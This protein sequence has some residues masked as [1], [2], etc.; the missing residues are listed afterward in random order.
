M[1]R[2]TVKI[3]IAAMSFMKESGSKTSEA[4]GVATTIKTAPRMKAN[5]C[6]IN[7]G[8]LACYDTVIFILLINKST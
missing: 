5:G 7:A 3:G 6:M 4:D 8:A 2:V 1:F